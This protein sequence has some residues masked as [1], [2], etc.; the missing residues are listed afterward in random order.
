MIRRASLMVAALIAAL[1]AAGASGCKCSQPGAAQSHVWNGAV[2]SYEEVAKVYNARV[3]PLTRLHAGLVLRL[4]YRD[5]DGAEQHFQVEGAYDFIR[6]RQASLF[7][8]KGGQSAAILGCD[9][10]RFWW[11]ELI[12]RKR[13]L[14]GE[15]DRVNAEQLSA[16]GVPVHPLDLIELLGIT[17]LPASGGQVRTSPAGELFVELPGRLGS[18]RLFLPDREFRPGRI[19]LLAP[20]GSLAAAA[21]LSKYASVAMAGAGPGVAHPFIATDAVI[22]AQNGD[23]KGHLELGAPVID[24]SRPKPRVFDLE[25]RLRAN[26]VEDVRQIA[27]VPLRPASNGERR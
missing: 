25:G 26:G 4:D 6:P 7:L 1:L 8:T 14:V 20:D 27:D 10:A 23:T 18:R 12:D 13:A 24:P 2:P 9:Q 15:H 11:I 19:E 17:P 22:V 21:D 16:A 3:E 5:Q